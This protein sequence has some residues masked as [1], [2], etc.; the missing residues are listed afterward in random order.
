[1]QIKGPRISKIYHNNNGYLCHTLNTRVF[2]G[3]WPLWLPPCERQT[4]EPSC[5]SVPAPVTAWDGGEKKYLQNK[6]DWQTWSHST[7]D[8]LIC[9]W[10]WWLIENN[11]IRD[12]GGGMTVTRKKSI[13]EVKCRIEDGAQDNKVCYHELAITQA[14]DPDLL[15]FRWPRSCQRSGR[16]WPPPPLP[17]SSWSIW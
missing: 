2:A 10:H 4:L 14:T 13:Q 5:D 11:I 15:M 7:G 3:S 12:S 9:S 16:L 17:A 6:T 8:I 1:M